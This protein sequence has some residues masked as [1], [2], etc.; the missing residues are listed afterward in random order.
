MNHQKIERIIKDFGHERLCGSKAEKEFAAY[1]KKEC[2]ELNIPAEIETFNIT[3]YEIGDEQLWID[4]EKIFCKAYMGCGCAD[5][6]APLFYMP[7][8]DEFSLAECKGKIVLLDNGVAEKKFRSLVESGALGL[9][10]RGGSIQHK[11]PFLRRRELRFA[12]RLEENIPCLLIGTEDYI[13]ILKNHKKQARIIVEQKALTRRSY[14]VAAEIEGEIEESIVL[15]AHIDSTEESLGVYDNLSGCMAL[16]EMA[17]YFANHRPY[18]TIQFLWCGSEE[19][20]LLGSI[21]YCRRH[22]AELKKAVCNIT[23]DMIGSMIGGFCM[24]ACANRESLE[25]MEGFAKEKKFSATSKFILRSTDVKPFVYAGVPAIS[26]ARYAGDEV[27]PIH[28]HYDTPEAVTP[29]SIIRDSRFICDFTAFLVNAEEFPIP[30]IIDEQMER[31]AKEYI[32]K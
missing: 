17:E 21:A 27:A 10:I 3:D 5:L 7:T 9:I 28:T 12:S 32:E 1:L 15:A 13:S 8:V 22:K 29:R 2:E 26:F 16:M 6:T 20:G 23:L 19:R 24:M 18:R 30:R 25:V 11:D 14:N 31:E 4:G